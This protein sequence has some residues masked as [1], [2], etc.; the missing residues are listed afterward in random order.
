VDNIRF[1]QWLT[2]HALSMVRA[3]DYLQVDI[4][5]VDRYRKGQM[6]IPRRISTACR[7]LDPLR[8]YELVPIDPAHP[9]WR[10][11]TRRT[12]VL[13][14]AQGETLARWQASCAF[15]VNVRRREG[16][17]ATPEDPWL[18]PART[19]CRRL[20]QAPKGCTMDG[21]PGVVD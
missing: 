20:R 19:A 11:S 7:A 1:E 13:V 16:E 2:D 9:D 18:N 3:A 14:R 5:T 8:L 4:K 17:D 21:Q 12:R 6:T 15:H 10:A